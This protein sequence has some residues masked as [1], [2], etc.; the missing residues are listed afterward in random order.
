M[1]SE[2]DTMKDWAEAGVI[3]D[4]EELTR[5]GSVSTT[6]IRGLEVL[7]CFRTAGETLSNAEIARRLNL[8]RPTVSRLCKT[9]ISQGFIRR[10]KTGTFRLAPKILTLAYPVLAASRWRHSAVGLMRDVAEFTSGNV[11][12]VVVSG[13][14]FVSVQSAGDA[15]NFPHVPEIGITGPLVASASGRALLSI[16][17]AQEFNDTLALSRLAYPDLFTRF[18]EHTVA[19]IERCRSDEGFCISYGDWRPSI[20]AASAPL[21]YTDDGL[22]VALTCAL[23]TYRSRREDMETD[24]G[25]RLVQAAN[26]LRQMGLFTL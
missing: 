18:A 12:L 4:H 14:D 19:G 8:N 13:A 5:D 16:L 7:S 2:L 23:P 6:L 20:Y 25:P 3:V 11:T 21:G 9:L 10:D 24:V 22:P 17:P 26:T 15:Q 1:S